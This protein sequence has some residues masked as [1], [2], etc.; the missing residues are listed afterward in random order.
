MERRRRDEIGFGQKPGAPSAIRRRQPARAERRD[1]EPVAVLEAEDEPARGPVIDG[2]R[3]PF[4]PGGGRVVAGVANRIRPAEIE[5]LAA[6]PAGGRRDEAKLAPA[7]G[8]E[9]ARLRHRRA[10]GGAGRRPDQIAQPRAPERERALAP[11]GGG[12]V[13]GAMQLFDHGVRLA[14]AGQLA[15]TLSQP[16][17]AGATFLVERAAGGVA[18]RLADV[19]RPFPSAL[20]HGAGFG[21]FAAALRGRAG[22]ERL[23]QTEPAP[24]LAALAA[25]AA[26]EAETLAA[27]EEA[28]PVEAGPFDLVVS[29]LTL[30]RANDPVGVLTQLRLSL[31]PDGLL[32]AAL[33]GGRT[34]FELRAALAEAEAEVEGGLSPRVAPMAEIRDAGALL[35][36]AGFAM[37]VADVDRFDVAYETPFHLMRDLRAMGEANPLAERRRGFTRR[38]TLLRAAELYARHFGRPDGRVNATFEIVF[39]A[40]WAPAPGQPEPK[41]PGSATHRLAEALG[42]E[43]RPL[44][45]QSPRRL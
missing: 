31:K 7:G 1:I 39:L 42:A 22:G 13:G 20:I 24:A 26:P 43:E 44:R 36:R 29:G 15:K 34:L 9:A 38:A 4:G 12:L 25:A 17:G 32:L 27:Q 21:R 35:Q 18:E 45:D 11:G 14:R 37:P 3:G 23:A 30:H 33:Y 28:P 8:A 10:A 5:R 19:A 2:G 16:E 40:G 6:K 41:R